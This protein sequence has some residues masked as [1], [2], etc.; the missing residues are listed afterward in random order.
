MKKSIALFGPF[1]GSLSWEFYRFAPLMIFLKRLYPDKKIAVLTRPER[2]DLYG[3]YAD[4]LIPLKLKGDKEKQQMFFTMKDFKLSKYGTL[5]RRFNIMYSKRFFVDS[6]YYP[7]ISDF[8]YK[9]RWQFSKSH[10]CYNFKPRLQ[11]NIVVKK[12]IKTKK[13]MLVIPANDDHFQKINKYVKNSGLHNKLSLF[14]CGYSN[15]IFQDINSIDEGNDIS[16]LGI[17]IEVLKNSILTIA[18][19]SDITHLSLLLKT[20]VLSWGSSLNL[21]M[22]NPFKTEITMLDDLPQPELIK[23][24]IEGRKTRYGKKLSSYNSI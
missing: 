6:H 14:S 7:D 23:K 4:Y 15:K 5:V 3:Q 20:P 1:I 12:F 9:V 18:P 10:M 22:I 17:L 21:D 24:I 11:N 2:F 8:R 13:T 19:K 16:R